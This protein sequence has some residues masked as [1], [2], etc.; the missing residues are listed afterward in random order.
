MKAIFRLCVLSVLLFCNLSTFKGSDAEL[1][2]DYLLL[3]GSEPIVGYA[4]DTTDNWWA[5]TSPYYEKYRLIVNGNE[6]EVFDDITRPVFSPDGKRW[7]CFGLYN[8]SWFLLTEDLVLDLPATSVGEIVYSADSKAMAY[9]FFES[10]LEII[11]FGSKSIE[12]LYRKGSIFVNQNG[13]K[14]AFMGL[15][16]TSM[17]L[18]VN[19]RESELF[20]QIKP[21]GFWY[22]GE[23]LYAAGSSPSW[24]IYKGNQPLSDIYYDISEVK[25][26][27]NGTCAAFVATLASGKKVSVMISDEY[28][29]ALVGKPYEAIYGLTLHPEIPLLAYKAINE[30]TNLIVLNSTEFFGGEFAGDPI[31]SHDGQD[32]LFVGCDTDCFANINGRKYAIY[33]D[34]NVR[35]KYAIKPGSGTIAYT[36]GATMI[37]RFLETGE[38]HA[39][40]MVD[41]VNH[42]RYNWR[43]NRFESLGKIN[44]RLY[45][46]T[47]EMGL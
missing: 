41:E 19:G 2:K 44:Q 8:S 20:D 6:S 11:R 24:Q 3:D 10:E 9:S 7:A 35:Q 42:I 25:I 34:I 21:F 36:T 38:L 28:Y 27:L 45:M 33:S 22:N 47:C 43:D 46:L 16:G 12:V 13:Q 29:D 26:N 4:M 1:C 18:N 15:R 23:M 31:F 14:I 17:V 30:R 39:G 5:I 37:V 32:L 40:M